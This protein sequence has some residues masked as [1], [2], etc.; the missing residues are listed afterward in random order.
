[1]EQD[2]KKKSSNS[3]CAIAVGLFVLVNIIYYFLT[4][5]KSDIAEK[6]AFFV[7]V[8]FLIAAYLGIKA[9]LR[10]TEDSDNKLVRIGV[11]IG[12]FIVLMVVLGAI[13]KDFNTMI[14]VGSIGFIIFCIVIGIL[15]YNSHKE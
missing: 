14:V 12:I 10:H 4:A 2:S 6:G 5:S 11:P 15:I 3:G 1:M 8:I 13:M 9:Y 7:F